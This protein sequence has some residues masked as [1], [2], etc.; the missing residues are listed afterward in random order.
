MMYEDVK[1]LCTIPEANPL[2]ISYI[3]MKKKHIKA[4]FT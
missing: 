1:S 2:Y 3:S 4:T